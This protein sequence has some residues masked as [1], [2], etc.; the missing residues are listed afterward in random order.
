MKLLR[1][2]LPTL[3][4]PLRRLEHLPPGVVVPRL[5]GSKLQQMRRRLIVRDGYRCQCDMC[6]AGGAPRPITLATM[7]LD[8]IVQVA[9]GGTN[10][11]SNLRC[12]HIECHARV[13]AAQRARSALAGG[14]AAR[15][16]G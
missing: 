12:L 9:D 4:S 7:E 8:H 3:R 2:S 14:E 10:D 15:P 13:S 6:E 5:R 1:P 16:G 11:P